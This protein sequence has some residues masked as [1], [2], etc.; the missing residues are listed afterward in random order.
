MECGIPYVY[1]M[2]DPRLVQPFFVDEATREVAIDRK[3]RGDTREVVIHYGGKKGVH[4]CR[5]QNER[6]ICCLNAKRQRRADTLPAK[7]GSRFTR[8]RCTPGLGSDNSCCPIR[9][10]RSGDKCSHYPCNLFATH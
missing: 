10:A 2:E 5:R 7:V 9:R 3:Q 4:R 8:I 6:C 1:P